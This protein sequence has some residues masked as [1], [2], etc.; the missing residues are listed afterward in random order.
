[1]GLE[2]GVGLIVWVGVYVDNIIL[3]SIERPSQADIYRFMVGKPPSMQFRTARSILETGTPPSL[4]SWRSA[5]ESQHSPSP[6][7]PQWSPPVVH[8]SPNQVVPR[9]LYEKT[10]SLPRRHLRHFMPAI[11]GVGSVDLPLLSSTPGTATTESG[12]ARNDH[13][14]K[15]INPHHNL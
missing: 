7:T 12:A 15:L 3:M 4:T 2:R 13:P 8:Y 14:L 1:M 11:I 10:L 5:P 6:S 9:I